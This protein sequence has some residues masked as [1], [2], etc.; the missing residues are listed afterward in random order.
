MLQLPLFDG[1]SPKPA[2][3]QKPTTDTSS[4]RSVTAPFI[5]ENPLAQLSDL[6]AL[7]SPLLKKRLDATYSLFRYPF[8]ALSPHPSTE[9]ITFRDK[10]GSEITIT[11][12]A[13][14]AATMNDKTLII[15]LISL[16]NKLKRQMAPEL[17]SRSITFTKNDY[18]M[19]CNRDRSGTG[20]Q[21]VIDM[22]AR[23]QGTVISTNI[24]T[25]DHG[26]RITFTFLQST[27]THYVSGKGGRKQI[28]AV[29]A[30]LPEWLYQQLISSDFTL[31]FHKDYF[32]ELSLTERRIYE[33]ARTY[34]KDAVVN[35][36]IDYFQS[37]VGSRSE[38]RKFKHD[39]KGIIK[40]Q[41]IPGYIIGLLGDRSSPLTKGL[42]RDGYDVARP[43]SE[44]L[45]SI[46]RRKGE[47]LSLLVDGGSDNTAD[48]AE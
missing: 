13:A 45:V 27:T 28:E 2:T 40:R 14:G 33:I 11:P 37:L 29:T 5:Q 26:K 3:D 9:T 31:Q 12:S 4:S 24:E 36:R 42:A 39:L 7:D 15:Y 6:P 41:P 47:G 35:F 34:C 38:L 1:T 48:N 16:F 21:A 19:A 22:L 20:Y 25:G 44:V 46:M 43:P 8:F 23:L 18:M 10:H 32:E 17:P 30:T